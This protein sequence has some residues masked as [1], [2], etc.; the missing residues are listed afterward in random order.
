LLVRYSGV[1]RYESLYRYSDTEVNHERLS[2]INAVMPA[3]VQFKAKLRHYPSDT[4][5][6]VLP[7]KG[8]GDGLVYQHSLKAKG[9]ESHLVLNNEGE[10]FTLVVPGINIV[11][12]VGIGEADNRPVPARPWF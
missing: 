5:D 10:S 11:S 2:K 6:A 3:G 12:S 9:I 7:C 8:W 1:A 4:L